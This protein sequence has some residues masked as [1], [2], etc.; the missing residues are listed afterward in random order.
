MTAEIPSIII[1]T[2]LGYFKTIT[3]RRNRLLLWFRGAKSVMM[4]DRQ[5]SFSHSG[6]LHHAAP[7]VGVQFLRIEDFGIFHARTPFTAGE[8]IDA[9]VDQAN[10][11][12]FLPFILLSRRNYMCG[13]E[14]NIFELIV[15]RYLHG[16]SIYFVT[17]ANINLRVKEADNKQ[18]NKPW[19]KQCDD[20]RP[21]SF[22]FI[23]QASVANMTALVT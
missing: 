7:L 15:G 2:G 14:N 12:T 20:F 22:L 17:S 3:A 10:E 13:F 9:E 23:R 18:S 6:G 5:N 19:F 1:L 8:C 11:L 4:F 21:N 16:V